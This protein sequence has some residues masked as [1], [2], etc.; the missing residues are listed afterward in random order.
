MTSGTHGSK[1]FA[2]GGGHCTAD[3]FFLA[4]EIPAWNAAIEALEKKKEESLLAAKREDEGMAILALDKPIAGRGG[5]SG[6]E[7]SQILL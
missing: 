4:A 7:L 6:E 1:F 2:T 3:D 5:L